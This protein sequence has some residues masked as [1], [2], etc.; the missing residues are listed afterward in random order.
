MTSYTYTPTAWTNGSTPLSQ[1]NMNNIETGVGN[2]SSFKVDKDGSTVM[3]GALQVQKTLGGGNQAYFTVLAPD[4]TN[5]Q[6]QELADQSFAV[7]NTG[8]GKAV[9]KF[10]NGGV[11][12]PLSN[13]QITTTLGGVNQVFCDF[14]ATD[15]KRYQIQEQGDLTFAVVNVTDNLPVLKIGTT[16]VVAQIASTQITQTLGGTNHVYLDMLATDGV[17][18]QIQEQADNSFAVVNATGAVLGLKITPTG[19]AVVI[20]PAQLSTG[21]QET[22]VCGFRNNQDFTNELHQV[23]VNFKTNMTNTPSSITMTATHAS[24]LVAG[25]WPVAV[26]EGVYG[27]H[28]QLKSSG[29]GDLEWRGQYTTVGN[30]ILALDETARTFDHHCDGKGR[31]GRE[32]GHIRRGLSIDTDL[33]V[34]EEGRDPGGYVLSAPACPVCGSVEHFHTG[35]AAADERLRTL[36]PRGRKQVFHAQ[37]YLIRRVQALRG[38]PMKP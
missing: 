33:A 32:C 1:A 3:T 2:A 13:M 7:V 12:V 14:I 9:V 34:N 21:S 28:F 8:T 35:F 17:R 20:A 30:C 22:G 38:L 18:W 19:Q 15:G 29:S 25:G 16:G 5:Y 27:F 26:A 37:P 10:T 23:P 24:G 11:L 36:K 6:I 31:D 4:G